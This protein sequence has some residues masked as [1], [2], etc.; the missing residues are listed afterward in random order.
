MTPNVSLN[1]IQTSVCGSRCSLTL[2]KNC[3]KKVENK[4]DVWQNVLNGPD[5][6]VTDFDMKR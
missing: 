5:F 1:V 3:G 6:Y 4:G 2:L